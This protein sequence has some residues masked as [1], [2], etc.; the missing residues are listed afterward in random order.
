MVLCVVVVGMCPLD[1]YFDVVGIVINLFVVDNGHVVWYFDVSILVVGAVLCVLILVL[2]W[3]LNTWAG[4]ITIGSY[5]FI[6][7]GSHVGFVAT[8]CFFIS[9]VLDIIGSAGSNAFIFV[10]VH[11]VVVGVDDN[12]AHFV[13]F[14][15]IGGVDD[16]GIHYVVRT[17]ITIII[18]MILVFESSWSVVSF[19]FMVTFAILG[20]I[21][22]LLVKDVFFC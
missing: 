16:Y 2:G 7:P 18:P 6:C 4:V 3:K 20:V 11:V 8:F 12:V 21:D 19:A 9:I 17:A 14:N 13:I 5:V 10:V 15:I 1:C 22:D